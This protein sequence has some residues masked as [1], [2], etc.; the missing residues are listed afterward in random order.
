M[1]LLWKGS[2]PTGYVIEKG[3]VKPEKIKQLNS[4]KTFPR[5][6]NVVHSFQSLKEDIKLAV[7]M[8]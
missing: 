6:T 4:S 7:T 1:F 5:L 2:S 3:I 8:R